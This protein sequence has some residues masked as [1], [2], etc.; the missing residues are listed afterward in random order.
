MPVNVANVQWS[1][2]PQAAR[3]V[4]GIV[5]VTVAAVFG[6]V[7]KANVSDVETL[8]RVQE[9]TQAQ[10]LQEVRALSREIHELRILVCDVNGRDSQCRR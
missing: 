7:S 3:A 9:A 1:D 5:S 4:I 2:I 8:R 10:V 6:W